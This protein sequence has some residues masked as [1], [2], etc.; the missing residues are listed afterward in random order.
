MNPA[1][2][3]GLALAAPVLAFVSPRSVAS[4]VLVATGDDVAAF[5]EHDADLAGEPQHRQHPQRHRRSSTSPGIA[6]AIGFRMNLFNIGVEGQ[7]R[8]AAFAAAVVAGEAWLPGQ[9]STPCWPSWS[10]WWPARCGPASPACC[11]SPAASA[12]SSRRSCS[13]PSRA[14]SSATCSARSASRTGVSTS[15]KTVPEEQLGR[16]LHSRSATPRPSS[17]ACCSSRSWSASPSACCSTDT[18]FGFDLRATG[19]PSPPRSP[20]GVNVKRMVVISMLLSGAV[21]GLIGMPMLFGEAH[22]YGSS[23]QTGIGF[24]GIA[25]ALLGRNNPVGIAFGALLFAFL[26][27]QGNLLNILAGVSPDIVAVT[28]GVIVLAVVIAYEVVRRYRVASSRPPSPSKS[29][30]ARARGGRRHERRRPRRRHRRRRA[31]ARLPSRRTASSGSWRTSSPR[32]CCV[33]LCRHDHRRRRH[34]LHRHPARRADRAR[35]RSLLAGL[36]GLWSERAGVVNIGL[37]GMMILGTLGAGYFG[38]HYGVVGRRRSAPS[39]F[40]A[41]GGA[42]ARARHRDLRRRPHR[43]RCR[44]QHHRARRG[45]V[46]RRGAAFTGLAGGGPTQSPPL[47][48]RPDDHDRAARRLRQRH[49]GQAAGSWSPTSLGVSACS[50]TGP[51]AAHP[52][53]ARCSSALTCVSCGAPVRPAAALLRR[54]PVGRRVA[55]RQRLPLQV[56]RRDRLRRPRRPRRRLPRDGVVQRLPER[57]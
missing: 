11:G 25:V 20:A 47:A 32:S 9:G 35:S 28:Q 45:G 12:R 55:R 21:A 30:P 44:D 53:R 8:V 22:N 41:I 57:P 39:L 52:G 37:E 50:S 7:Y 5:W 19:R 4:L 42:A 40:G 3:I 15:T 29:R 33:S 46:P 2:R 27:E 10:R 6:A 17:T 31:P 16:R 34:Q 38:Y 24:A 23:F 48:R 18:R 13:T 54:G 51:V 49:R 43:L 56:R 36:G 26:D 14:C 1:K